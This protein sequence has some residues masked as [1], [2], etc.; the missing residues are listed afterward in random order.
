MKMGK[1]KRSIQMISMIVS[2]VLI[3][4]FIVPAPISV[5]ATS[6]PYLIKVNKQ[7][8]CVTVYEK[9]SSGNYTVPIKAM[10]CST[11]ADT[12]L[13]TYKTPNKYRWWMLM[14]DVWGQYCTRIT[15]GI[16][17]HSV[18]YYEKDPSTLSAVQYNKLGTM[19]SHGCIRLTVADAKWIYDNCPLGTTVQIYNSS[20]PGPLGKPTA[21]KLPTNQGWDPTDPDPNNP[22][23]GKPSL[24]TPVLDGVKDQTVAY[25]AAIDI[26]KG[27]TAKDSSG[28]TATSKITTSITYGGQTVSTINTQQPGTYKVTYTLPDSSG[29]VSKSATITVQQS[30]AKPV[31]YGTR[32]LYVNNVEKLTD[33]YLKRDVSATFLDKPMSKSQI[34]VALTRKSNSKY[35]VKYSVTASNGKTKYKTVYAFIDSKPPVL[36]GI[37]DKNIAWDT[38]VN[39]AFALDGVTVKDNKTKLTL[40]DVEV[41][42]KETKKGYQVTYKVSDELKNKTVKKAVY[43]I[44]D[45]LRIKGAKDHILSADANL[46]DESV[47]LNGVTAYDGDADITEWLQLEIN[48]VDSN[49]YRVTYSISNEYGDVESVTVMITKPDAQ[50]SEIGSG[51]AVTATDS[52]VNVEEE[53]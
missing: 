52:A 6:Y 30:T 2:L 40:K 51:S 13:G 49:V 24:V 17:F 16:L 25:G 14:G 38:K 5:K 44:T 53:E 20:T 3:F 1:R 47:W 21:A 4:S 32:N 11:G 26:M 23:K 41:T 15:G 35:A 9:D 22:Y 7:A 45:R 46:E 36:K 48:K 8:N 34:Q 12:P 28:S 43:T 37:K 50:D 42:I 10:V 33:S 18:W 29:N 27:V 19:C 31:I 39:Q